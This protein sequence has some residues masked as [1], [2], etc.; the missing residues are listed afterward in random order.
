MPL[1]ARHTPHK[2]IRLGQSS[3]S[4]LHC[5]RYRGHR[6]WEREVKVGVQLTI[7]AHNEYAPPFLRHREV[8]GV[9]RGFECIEPRLLEEPPES[10]ELFYVLLGHQ[11]RDVFKDEEADA[12]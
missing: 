10:A 12:V 11:A 2:L 9:E 3:Y 1:P 6:P 8:L 5:H 7:D 4:L